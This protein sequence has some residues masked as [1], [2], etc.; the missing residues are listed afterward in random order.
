MYNSL[1]TSAVLK[2]GSLQKPVSTK[3]N[4]N[5]ASDFTSVL[6]SIAQFPDISFRQTGLFLFFKISLIYI[7]GFSSVL[8]I[9]AVSCLLKI[10]YSC[11][12]SL[13]LIIADHKDS[14]PLLLTAGKNA[15]HY[16]L[17]DSCSS[18]TSASQSLAQHPD[19][20]LHIA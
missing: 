1:L 9:L 13:I 16:T 5:F 18:S 20:S 14:K 10:T 15:Q 6:L 4:E 19:S 7:L 12:C 17:P 2:I 8:F 11:V 3:I